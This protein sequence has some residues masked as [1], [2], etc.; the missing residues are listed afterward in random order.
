MRADRNFKEHRHVRAYTPTLL[1]MFEYGG[2]HMRNQL[3]DM[4]ANEFKYTEGTV[5]L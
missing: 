4:A 5:R 3:V 1:L 2:Q